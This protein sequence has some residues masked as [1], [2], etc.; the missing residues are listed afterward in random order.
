MIAPPL[1]DEP[2]PGLRSFRRDETHIFFGR[3]TCI[4]DMVQRL[5]AHRF[6]AVT[7][8]SGSGKSSLVRTG[9]LDALDRGLLAAAGADWRFADFRPG[10]NPLAELA[11]ALIT[12]IG[13][14]DSEQDRL[15]VEAMLARGP[16][17][18]VEWIES[19]DLSPDTS[20]LLL[21]DQF[22]E[23]FRFRRGRTGDDVNA[24][25]ALLLASAGQRKRPIYVV[26]TMRSDFLGE[27]SQFT[28]LA[29]AINDGQYLTPRLTRE[30]CRSAIEGPAAVFGGRVESALTNRLLNDMGTNAD[31]LPLAQHALMR[32]WRI[33]SARTGPDAGVLK[34]EDYEKLGGIGSAPGA[35]GAPAG[36]Q[37]NALSAHAD[38][39]LAGLAPDQQHLA[40]I[41]FRALT[42]SHGAGGRDVRRPIALGEAAAVASVTPEQLVP[43]IDAFRAPGRNLITPPINIPLTPQTVIDISHESL[44]RQWGTLREWLRE[45]ADAARIYL[46]VE[47]NAKLW[48]EG[49]SGLMTMPYL[50]I[51][52]AWR[53]REQ[54]NA[55]WA[56]RYGD[57]FDLAM[58]FLNQSFAAE[59]QRIETEEAARRRSA[60]R[61]RTVAIAMT[62]LAIIAGG[63]AYFGF[64]AANKAQKSAEEA[65]RAETL[66][67]QMSDQ[68]LKE[69]DSAQ[70]GQSNYLAELARERFKDGELLYS[71]LYSVEA[72]PDQKHN[73]S[74]PEIREAREMLMQSYLQLVTQKSPLTH[75]T[76][77]SGLQFLPAGD[78][79]LSASDDGTARVWDLNGWPVF[80]LTGHIGPVTGTDVTPDGKLIATASLDGIARIWDGGSGRLLI[81]IPG[82]VR[83][84]AISIRSDGKAAVTG[85]SDGIAR[86]WDIAT[87]R[88]IGELKGQSSD[89]KS[90]H[91]S[92]DGSQVLIVTDKVAQVWDSQ[93]DKLLKEINFGYESVLR[94]A[95]AANGA[96]IA[97]LGTYQTAAIWDAKT[98]K[99]IASFKRDCCNS[100]FAVNP[101][102][103]LLA[104]VGG[105]DDVA[106]IYD[107]QT[108]KKIWSTPI[109]H[110]QNLTFSP[111]GS[112][113]ITFSWSNDTIAIWDAE[114][115]N[116]LSAIKA[117]QRISSFA[118][119]PDG[120]HIAAFTN[121]GNLTFWTIK[122]KS[123]STNSIANKGGGSLIL[124][125][126][127]RRFLYAQDGGS[128]TVWDAPAQ[129]ML[130]TLLA[131]HSTP[132]GA[133][134]PKGQWIA[135][136]S[137]DTGIGIWENGNLHHA[138]DIANVAASG[139]AFDPGGRVLATSTTTTQFD[140]FDDKTDVRSSEATEALGSVKFG[141]L[142]RDGHELFVAGPGSVGQVW[143]ID[144]GRMVATIVE[145]GLFSDSAIFTPDGTR[146]VTQ[147]ENGAARL[148]DARTG[149]QLA[150][151][152]TDGAGFRFN[153]S[154]DRMLTKT[155]AG[156][157]RI[158]D[159]SSG[160]MLLLQV[161]NAGTNFMMSGYG[162]TAI[163]WT[164]HQL[165]VLDTR[166]GR[167]IGNI[168]LESSS[169]PQISAD[170]S[171]I[172]VEHGATVAIWDAHTLQ[173]TSALAGTWENVQHINV[174][175]NTDASRLIVKDDK[176][177]AQL[178][179]G[180]SGT[181]MT[182]LDDQFQDGAIVFTRDG[183][184]A[185]LARQDG[186]I[187]LW[188]VVAGKR[189]AGL[190]PGGAGFRLGVAFSDDSNILVTTTAGLTARV[191]NARTG[192]HIADLTGHA[193]QVVR[194]WVSPD[195]KRIVTLSKDGV[196][197]VWDAHTA[198]KIVGF[199]APQT[200]RSI[201]FSAD[202]ARIVSV[203]SQSQTELFAAGTWKVIGH[204]AG[205]ATSP[206]TAFSPDGQYLLTVLGTDA[207][208]WQIA[209]GRDVVTLHG[210]TANIDDATFSPDGALI[211][212]VSEDK[213]GRIW[214]A[215]TGA[216]LAVLK[217][218]EN[219]IKKG[220]F[221]LD[222]KYVVT[223]SASGEVNLWRTADGSL[224]SNLGPGKNY[225]T[226]VPE[227]DGKTVALFTDH[228]MTEY[229]LG[230][231]Q[232]GGKVTT[233]ISLVEGTQA[234]INYVNA[235]FGNL[236]TSTDRSLMNSGKVLWHMPW[237]TQDY[238]DAVHDMLP[239]CLTPDERRKAY[240]DPQPP[241]WCIDMGKWPYNTPA[242]K[243]W[244]AAKEAGK[245]EPMPQGQ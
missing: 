197:L 223:I 140:V 114:K 62:V 143:D 201:L 184:R 190:E 245:D 33:A 103:S 232:A 242:W 28:G 238:V 102:G 124:S 116:Q 230:G 58:E 194:L 137:A 64:Q 240:L 110:V 83:L 210:H 187:D 239:R 235:P 6:L 66:A 211:L 11:A 48:R 133:F 24:F 60:W 218:N 88:Q 182:A 1:T 138:A 186:R 142:S 147:A 229:E 95:Y 152:Q 27:C 162:D 26:I 4:N 244:L 69:K 41:L 99:P 226:M 214:N 158:W 132:L 107:V 50:G 175:P 219:P 153:A 150:L 53:E 130:G 209:S 51:A 46:H 237:S 134:D 174:Y 63:F 135:A 35:D 200:T 8:T 59:Q 54:P 151:L 234:G 163:V 44:I 7:G 179:D 5:A 213:T 241:A 243:Q 168:K 193:A 42:E 212:T 55:A 43:V 40:S 109:Q 25:V 154:G 100:N 161:A 12:A 113:L 108:L 159:L 105:M 68:A 30:E 145:P 169:F 225:T 170:G 112:Q 204:L 127:G 207:K 180:A 98:L 144:T 71:L 97:L 70:R 128:T 216:A 122:E 205:R 131:S 121:Q 32:L 90:V 21:A 74:R 181:K 17:G 80:E 15:R 208:V 191:W 78:R 19:T 155:Q 222:G 79:V 203:D 126:D 72:L 29:E 192:E 75:A 129:K 136:L 117:D 227:P 20:L 221:S 217:G 177:A 236:V 94:A 39:I 89:I 86:I 166:L 57:D 16:L 188:D 84:R 119:S 76:S 220:Q 96:R 176:G 198:A 106:E 81:Q 65:S 183:S 185:V 73:V 146:L 224:V 56:K 196:A 125:G 171:R 92:P 52:R 164:D 34:L 111:D 38:E 156:E 3:E 228:D 31:Q 9:L 160:K 10:N 23:I 199:T 120:K 195:S 104:I 215:K 123:L 45:E 14:P 189:L 149:T 233:S 101:D 61:T 85:G 231:Q 93:G 167:E 37:V 67:N 165:K 36:G 141:I 22:E 18:L 202:G 157:A 91:F 139:V 2:Y 115:G 118:V 172:V 82:M 49:N 148:L 178:F 206:A 173:Q 77:V 13:M 47:A 87:G